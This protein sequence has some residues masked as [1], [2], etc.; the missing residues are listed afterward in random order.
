MNPTARLSFPEHLPGAMK[1]IENNGWVALTWGP[2]SG[3]DR[4]KM[5]GVVQ[6]FTLHWH[7]RGWGQQRL[8][9]RWQAGQGR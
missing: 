9:H 3:L 7:P 1:H 6:P 5:P 4:V 8:G 2:K